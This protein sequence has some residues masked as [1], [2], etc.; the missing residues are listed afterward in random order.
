[1]KKLM[2]AYMVVLMTIV[3]S[4][5]AFA[6]EAEP[7]K[8][9]EKKAEAPEK[10]KAPEPAAPGVQAP[11]GMVYIPAGEF[12]MGSTNEQVETVAAKYGGRFV[13]EPELPQRK[14][15]VTACFIDK[16]PVSNA[17]YKEFA[18]ATGQKQPYH[19][20]NGTYPAGKGDHPVT[21]VTWHDAAEYAKWAGKRL[22]TEDEWEK[23]ARGT[24]GRLYPWGDEFSLER[25]NA[26]VWG[27]QNIDDTTP[28]DSYENGKSPYG[29]YGMAG[30]V[31]EW[32]GSADQ[33]QLKAGEE[34][35]VLRGGSYKSFDTY[36]RCAF[37]LVFDPG[38]FGPH[39]GFRCAKD[40]K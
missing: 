35:R 26:R 22:A 39:I 36:A 24:D 11:A 18:D 30:N 28:V 25:C 6:G 4:A 9:D 27:A 3:T 1:M 8:T 5:A 23:A 31:W 13:Y 14:V 19:W 38:A 34:N 32:S 20:A 40:V 33:K 21:Y 37:R 7:A 29:C 15:M 10:E 2:A 17:Q 16:F 12:V